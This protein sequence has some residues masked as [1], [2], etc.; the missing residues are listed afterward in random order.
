MFLTTYCTCIHIYVLSIFVVFTKISCM[1]AIIVQVFFAYR[2]DV[3]SL[4]M[5]VLYYCMDQFLFQ[6][7]CENK[8]CMCKPYNYSH[9]KG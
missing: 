3:G 8:L 4:C 5:S 7:N 1:V 9:N 6:I 2:G